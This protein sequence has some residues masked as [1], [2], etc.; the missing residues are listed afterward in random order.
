MVVDLLVAVSLV[1]HCLIMESVEL[2]CHTYVVIH[3]LAW[4]FE[5]VKVESL[6]HLTCYINLSGFHLHMVSMESE[7]LFKTS[8]NLGIVLRDHMVID[9]NIISLGLNLCLDQAD[10]LSFIVNTQLL[11]HFLFT[12][13]IPFIDP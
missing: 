11:I 1:L 3:H 5:Q 7:L 12:I 13:A 9:P 2:G 6:S 8:V 10:A 4:V